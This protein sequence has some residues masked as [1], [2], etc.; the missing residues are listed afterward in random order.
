MASE[1]IETLVNR[2]NKTRNSI[3]RMRLALRFFAKSKNYSREPIGWGED[4]AYI[5]DG[6]EVARA[7][8]RKSAKSIGGPRE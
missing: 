4:Y 5:D 3:K 8:L 7:A 6:S 2:I 1:S